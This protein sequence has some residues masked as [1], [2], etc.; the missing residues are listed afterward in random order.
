MIARAVVAALNLAYRILWSARP[1]K[2][3]VLLAVLCYSSGLIFYTDACFGISDNRV[4]NRIVFYSENYKRETCLTCNKVR[5]SI[6]ERIMRRRESPPWTNDGNAI[7]RMGHQLNKRYFCVDGMSFKAKLRLEYDRRAS[8]CVLKVQDD[9]NAFLNRL[10]V[11]A[12]IDKIASVE[13]FEGKPSSLCIDGLNSGISRLYGGQ[14]A[15]LCNISLLSYTSL[16]DENKLYCGA[17]QNKCAYGKDKSEKRRRI[18]KKNVPKLLL[19]V[20]VFASI[21]GTCWGGYAIT[22]EISSISVAKIKTVR[23]LRDK[24]AKKRNIRSSRLKILQPYPFKLQ[25]GKAGQ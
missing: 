2:E 11:Y 19:W 6:V 25:R 8:S 5:L 16:S 24:A 13:S 3:T 10:V 23:K 7:F 4:G 22:G 21:C 9:D 12:P 14:K 20:A 15:L 18:M 1:T 17:S